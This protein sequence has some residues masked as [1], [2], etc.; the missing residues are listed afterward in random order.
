M[1]ITYLPR[2]VYESS[3]AM[4]KQGMVSV[5]VAFVVAGTVALVTVLA[6]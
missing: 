2:E 1:Q 4:W 3:G 6:R 5:V